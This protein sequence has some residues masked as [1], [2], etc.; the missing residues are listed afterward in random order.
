MPITGFAARIHKNY[1]GSV[2]DLLS[3]TTADA[4]TMANISSKQV[5]GLI[6]TFLPGVFDGYAHSHF[7][8]NQLRQYLGLRARHVEILDFGGPSVL[9]MIYRAEKAIK[10]GE[11]STVLCIAGGKGSH[12]RKKGVTVDS[13]DRVY[14]DV[15]LT[16]FDSLFRLYPDLN[17]VSDYALVAKR[18]SKL[19]GTSD[20]DRAKIAV[21]QRFN[22]KHNDGAL[23][24]DE[25][26]VED[27][28]NSPLVSDPL[29]LLEIVYPVDG[30]HAFIVSDRPSQLAEVKILGY[31]E[32]HWEEM[33]TELPDI[34]QTPA[35]ESARLAAF[36]PGRADVLELYDSFT[37]TVMLQL[38]D[39]GLAKKGSVGRFLETRD[40]T[41][42]GDTPVN[43]GGGSLNCG[44]PAFM[45]GGVILHEALLQLND[46]AKGHQV[47]GAKSAFIN[48]IGGW[49]RSHSVTL[50]L[51][52]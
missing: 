29:H 20:E 11:A 7:F 6:T 33:P 4:L 50:V 30:F 3:E 22:A 18:H 10:A 8:T 25:L 49:N 16:P 27:V 35:T 51:G 48:G 14:P 31:G 46:M 34:I 23:Y 9:A 38:E 24:R 42:K 28:L 2:F 45:S 19:F 21:Q 15:S 40:L 1:E 37:I 41:F 47:G 43:T 13:I 17:P 36:D 12:L 44:Q 26:T 32:A 39:I 52:R 5:D